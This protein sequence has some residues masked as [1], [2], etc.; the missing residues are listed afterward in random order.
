M[1]KRRPSIKY[2]LENRAP[3]LL[4]ISGLGSCTWDLSAVGN[5]P[6]NFCFIGA[7]GQAAPFALGLALAQPRKRVVLFTGDGDILMSLGV[8]TTI[9]NLAPSNLCIVIMDNEVYGETGGQPTAT[10]GRTD[11]VSI[12][13]G[14]GFASAVDVSRDSE[15]EALRDTIRHGNALSFANIK[16]VEESLPLVFPYS[17]DGVTSIN[18]FRDAAMA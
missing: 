16:V 3:D 17:F 9:A 8:L 18:R 11:L 2:L 4:A 10:A 14:A 15:L 7:M 12:A 5:V 1:L 6:E 13:R